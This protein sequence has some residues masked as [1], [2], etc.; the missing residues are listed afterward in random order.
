ML[1]SHNAA[2]STEKCAT[3][4]KICSHRSGNR[5]A[6]LTQRIENTM[7]KTVTTIENYPRRLQNVISAIQTLATVAESAR[8]CTKIS[9]LRHSNSDT[10]V[11]ILDSKNP[12]ILSTN[13]LQEKVPSWRSNNVQEAMCAAAL[14]NLG[15]SNIV[16]EKLN[17]FLKAY[18]NCNL[19]LWK[20]FIFIAS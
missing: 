11:Q 20:K 15:G 18:Q 17:D 1:M 19:L 4:P 10:P 12:R 16:M 3:N 13:T 14:A 9:E 2:S 8:N 5:A 7:P 6:I